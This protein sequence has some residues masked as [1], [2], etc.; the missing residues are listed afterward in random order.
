MQTTK[1]QFDNAR[2]WDNATNLCMPEKRIETRLKPICAPNPSP[3]I[4]RMRKMR[5][6]CLPVGFLSL[7][8]RIR[9]RANGSL[10]PVGGKCQM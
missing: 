1:K 3:D 2:Q 9:K 8:S 7:A 4:A 6:M 5:P 10:S